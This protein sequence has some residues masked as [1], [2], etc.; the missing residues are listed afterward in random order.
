MPT[1]LTNKVEEPRMPKG[2]TILILN[3]VFN[4]GFSCILMIIRIVFQS[5]K[6]PNANL[7]QFTL[8]MRN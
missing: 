1:T 8:H 2:I 7:M 5:I 3:Y 6:L 4:T